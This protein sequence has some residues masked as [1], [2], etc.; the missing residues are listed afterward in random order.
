MKNNSLN[1]IIDLT[2]DISS[3]S[4]NDETFDTILL[5]A[6]LPTNTGEKS[7][8]NVFQVASTDEL[9]SYGYTTTDELYTAC[10]VAFSQSPSP[11]SISVIAR[12]VTSEI[13]ETIDDC[14]TRAAKEAKFYG[15]YIVGSPTTDELEA[16][17]EWAES[18]EK[19]FVFTYTTMNTFPIVN[20]SYYRTAAF[21]GGQADGYDA[22]SQ[23]AENKYVGLAAMAKCFGYDP[24]SETWSLKPLATVVPSALSAS[25]KVIL[26][27]KNATS[28]RRY[29]GANTTYGGMVI[30]G[31]WIDVIRFRDWLKSEI[32]TNVFN[33]LK[34]N[35]KVPF[36]D[37]GINMIYG[38]VNDA[39]AKGQRIGGIADDSADDDGNVTAGYSITIPKASS[40]TEAERNSRKLTGI[41]WEARLSGAIHFAKLTG[42]IAA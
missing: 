14:L 6:D 29:A 9:K 17:K 18:N 42:T 3:P 38:A 22:E 8:D 25:D 16:A 2:I 26:E 33:A 5:V 11:N 28:V 36:T 27:N 37:A 20:T 39:L 12:T 31:E 1:D 4:A 41:T 40:F 15:I 10:R 34:T 23:P 35:K 19:L 32:Q 30:G 24:G 13:K 21:Y 7:T